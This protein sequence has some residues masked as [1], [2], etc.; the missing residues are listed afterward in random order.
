MSTND[1]AKLAGVK[2]CLD[3]YNDALNHREWDKVPTFYSDDC[4]WY[5]TNFRDF[6][7]IGSKAIGEGLKGNASLTKLWLE[8]NNL[9]DKGKS[10]VTSGWGNRDGSLDL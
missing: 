10:V 2:A 4:K 1:A 8:N 9:T 5:T 6:S 3:G 7:F